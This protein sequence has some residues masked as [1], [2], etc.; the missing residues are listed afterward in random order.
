MSILKF[1]YGTGRIF[2][3]TIYLIIF[4][5]SFLFSFGSSISNAEPV[6]I[7]GY[8]RSELTAS[9]SEST[10]FMIL[11]RLR[12]D[13]ETSLSRKLYLAG[14]FNLIFYGGDDEGNF[15]NNIPDSISGSVPSGLRN[16]FRY[17]FDD[18]MEWDNI[19]FQYRFERFDLTV[20]K[21]QINFGSGYA[22][23][24][25][26]V[27][28][29]K[30]LIDPGE[31][32]SG[33]KALRIDYPLSLSSRF[34]FLYDLEDKYD[35]P[36]VLLQYKTNL[37]HFDYS[38]TFADR[39]L[40]RVD[41]NS[42]STLRY[43]RKMAGLSVVGEAFGLGVWFEGAYNWIDGNDNFY[44]FVVGWNYTWQNSFYLLVE[45]FHST[46]GYSDS[47]NYD[48][49]GWMRFISGEISSLSRDNLY[50]YCSYPWNDLT[51]VGLAV[52][53]SISDG[54]M[55]LIPTVEYSLF[56]DIYLEFFGAVN[57]GDEGTL[58]SRELG[59]GVLAKLTWYF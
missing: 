26:D 58:F 41:H 15:L 36:G 12:L 7:F 43:R 13:F 11:N 59:N 16:S 27:F 39:Y 19:F 9:D 3:S 50:L 56:N 55:V 10:G 34:L 24:P 4:I 40:Y 2:S 51:T 57:T 30:S 5:L 17:S 47:G 32:K 45:Y 44:E 20:G 42:F 23:N 38:I 22:W 46:Q 49:N 31:E 6:Q 1:P 21:Q 35:D 33:H 48:L 28:N 29:V 14:N 18:D 37:G 8:F 52:A 25:T 53:S 54:S